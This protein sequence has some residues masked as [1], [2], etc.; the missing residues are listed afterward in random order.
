MIAERT[1][2]Y[3]TPFYFT[4]GKLP[5]PKY[6]L[7]IKTYNGDLMMANLPSSQNYIPFPHENIKHGC[8]SLDEHN[9][10]CYCFLKGISVTDTEHKFTLNTFLYGKWME[11]YSIQKWL[12]NYTKEGKDFKIAVRYR[13][14]YT[15]TF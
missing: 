8:I 6:C 3:L 5:S 10:H 7:V 1:V 13:K 4:D 15:R 9:F 14:S 2:L 11:D 12:A